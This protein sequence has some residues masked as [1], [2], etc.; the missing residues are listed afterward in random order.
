M[1]AAD[2]NAKAIVVYT[3]SGFTARA[4]AQFRPSCPI[5]ALTPH[6]H[7]CRQLTLCWGTVPVCSEFYSVT[8]DMFIGAKKCVIDAGFAGQGDEIIVTTGLPR[9]NTGSTTLLRVMK[10]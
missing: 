10:L 5:M 9:G 3:V 7:I 4:V 8:E 6:E 1:L 2:I